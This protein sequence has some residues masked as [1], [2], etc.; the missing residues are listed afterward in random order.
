MSGAPAFLKVRFTTRRSVGA[1][2]PLAISR[3]SESTIHSWERA[4]REIGASASIVGNFDRVLIRVVDVDRLDRAERA[5]RRALH[6]DRN[7]ATF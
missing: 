5:G 2:R 1:M 4:G 6:P 3:K 7:A